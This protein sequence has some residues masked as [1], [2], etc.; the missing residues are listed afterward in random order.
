[1]ASLAQLL[2][3]K[4]DAGPAA[5]PH[6][7]PNFRNYERL[8]DT[9]VVR[10]TFF[11][12]TAA[13]AI[14]AC[15][16]LWTG[17]REFRINTLKQ[18]AADAQ[19]QIDANSRQNAEAMRSS[20]LFADEEKKVAEVTRFVAI[21]IQP[22]EFITILGDTLPTNVGIT[23]VDMRLREPKGPMVVLRGTVAGSPDQASGMASR[24]V[25]VFRSDPRLVAVVESAEMTDLNRDP[26][27]S[28]VSF[29][30][31]LRFKDAAKGGK[32]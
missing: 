32:S 2:S 9:K 24:Y 28:G 8:P 12:N 30:I 3:R 4:S 11:V 17:Y 27:G 26:T 6:W 31:V 19:A 21:V 20:K 14:A 5:A 1:M 29:Q 23:G 25:D 16:V 13:I 22:T 7:H 18:Q 10:T 15:L